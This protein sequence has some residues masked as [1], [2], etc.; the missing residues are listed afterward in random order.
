M[1]EERSFLNLSIP[2]SFM[3]LTK[4]SK[5]T[6]LILEITGVLGMGSVSYLGSGLWL[7]ILVVKLTTSR[8]N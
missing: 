8:I 7:L 1:P 5:K 6:N 4:A 2:V 3:P